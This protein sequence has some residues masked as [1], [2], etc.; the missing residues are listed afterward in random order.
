M[1]ANPRITEDQLEALKEEAARTGRVQSRGVEPAGIPSVKPASAASYHG[2]P[3]LKPPTW[4]W[5]VPLYFFVG[6]VAGVSSLIALA[7]HVA[8]NVRLVRVELWVGF[9]G[10]LLSA[11]LLIADLGRPSR[12]LNMLRVF[13]PRSAMSLGAWTLSAFSSAVG[14]AFVCR[15]LILAGFGNELFLI[16]EWLAEFLA[17]FTGLVLASYTSVLLGVSAIPVWSENRRL[18]PVVFLTGA[19]G[20][21]GAVLELCGFMI[22]AT[23]FIGLAASTAEIG[24]AIMIEV[25][26]RYVDRPLREG[27]TGWLTRAG[28]ILAGPVALLLRIFAGHNPAAG[29]LAA[30]CF[31]AGALVARYAWVGA[32]RVSSR[33]PQALFRIQRS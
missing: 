26:G 10:A 30:I 25:R 28:A 22:P 7:A 19:L 17:A 1:A 2:N 27:A 15:E 24:I 8:G 12:F 20:S 13:K 5:Q 21:A 11:P 29:D 9:I 4:T 33:D 16:V 14:L 31:I 18:V 32:G 23:R 6:G 3:V